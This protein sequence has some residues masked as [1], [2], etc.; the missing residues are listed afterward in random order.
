MNN[1][2]VTAYLPDYMEDNLPE[3][4]RRRIE[5]HLESC[6]P[7]REELAYL[8]GIRNFLAGRPE[9]PSP[10]LW[11]G[12]AE[13]IALEE[14]P[15]L[16]KQFEWVGKRLVPLMAAA[17]VLILA[18]FGG[19]NGTDPDPTLEEY[20]KAQWEGPEVVMLSDAEL[21]QDDVFYLTHTR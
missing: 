16:W 21:S 13:R 17:A 4:E 12:V 7:C 9:S 18:I 1:G 20:L 14:T 6:A 3:S 5:A 11:A 2:H 15:G 19:L 8:Q 10:G